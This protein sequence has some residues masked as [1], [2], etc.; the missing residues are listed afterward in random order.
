MFRE[1]YIKEDKILEKT[2]DELRNDL[3]TDLEK[4]R[5]SLNNLY[6]NLKFASGDLVDYYTYKIKAEEARYR[7]FN[8][9]NQRYS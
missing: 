1:D 7:F 3:Y 8:K 9:R 2:K 4:S 6:Q 5:N